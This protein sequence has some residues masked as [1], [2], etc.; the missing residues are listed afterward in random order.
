MK[1]KITVSIDEGLLQELDGLVEGEKYES[2]SAAVEAAIVELQ[3]RL[4]D[5][6]FERGLALLDPAEERALADEGL[7][8]YA[9]LVA[10]QDA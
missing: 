8:D 7:A 6:E 10:G 4:C 1:A 5:A 9:A 3:R 2:R